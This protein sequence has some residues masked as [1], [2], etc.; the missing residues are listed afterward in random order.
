MERHTGIVS[1]KDPYVPGE[2]CVQRP[3]E[4]I[5][6]QGGAGME[7]SDLPKGM[8]P[9]IGPAGSG[10]PNTFPGNAPYRIGEDI[11]NGAPGLL[12]LPSLIFSAV[13][14]QQEL[15]APHGR[16]VTGPGAAGISY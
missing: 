7:R 14:L 12:R 15:Y 9:G 8:H 1:G 3:P 13:V 10:K 11:L 6:G 5:N 16:M 4:Y 2:P